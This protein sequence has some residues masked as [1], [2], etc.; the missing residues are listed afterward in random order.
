MIV[1]IHYIISSTVCAKLENLILCVNY[2]RSVDHKNEDD[3]VAITDQFPV[4]IM[5]TISNTKAK[6]ES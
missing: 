5:T 2:L 6:E 3:S 4:R 1:D